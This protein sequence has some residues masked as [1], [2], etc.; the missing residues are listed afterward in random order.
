MLIKI[1]PITFFRVMDPH[2]RCLQAKI[3]KRN[4][5]KQVM[6]KGQDRVRLLEI[7]MIW[8][9][10]TEFPTSFNKTCTYIMALTCVDNHRCLFLQIRVISK[11]T[12]RIH[13]VIMDQRKLYKNY[14]LK[15]VGWL[16]V[17]NIPSTARRHPIYCPLWRTWS[18]IFTPFQPG[19]E[20]RAV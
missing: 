15:L 18:S 7:N 16:V 20:P 19:F 9:F 4:E 6:Q 12:I 2:Q 8:T 13:S 3:E 11:L 14:C 17:F 10:H 1:Y 5:A